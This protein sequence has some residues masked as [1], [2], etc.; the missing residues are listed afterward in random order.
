M[1]YKLHKYNLYYTF[2]CI[3][4]YIHIYTTD[5]VH[6]DC[7]KGPHSFFAKGANSLSISAYLDSLLSDLLHIKV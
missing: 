5:L 6:M 7:K 3:Y 4:I 1:I 2:V